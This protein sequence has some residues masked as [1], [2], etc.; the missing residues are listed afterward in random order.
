MAMSQRKAAQPEESKEELKGSGMIIAFLNRIEASGMGIPLRG[1]YEDFRPLVKRGVAVA[2]NVLQVLDNV[3]GLPA[4]F[5]NHH[6][7]RFRERYKA[8]LE[9]IPDKNRQLPPFRL[10]CTVLKE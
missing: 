8:R 1:A 4:D 10:G 5:L 9:A 6:L 7:G 3:I 2:D